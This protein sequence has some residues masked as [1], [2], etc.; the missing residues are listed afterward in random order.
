[1]F[2]QDPRIAAAKSVVSDAARSLADLLEDVQSACS[3]T[4]VLHWNHDAEGYG[5][6]GHPRR[7]CPRCLAV[8]EGSWWS[9]PRNWRREDGNA[10]TMGTAPERGI[11][12]VRHETYIRAERG[13]LSAAPV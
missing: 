2:E 11:H 12:E 10:S 13:E 9:S 8:E 4:V 7:I 5:G 6:T 1:M 3:H